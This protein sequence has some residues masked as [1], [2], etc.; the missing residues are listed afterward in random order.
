M[1]D[2]GNFNNAAENEEYRN[3]VLKTTFANQR[4]LYAAY[5]TLF[6]HGGIFIPTTR[7][8]KL[9]DAIYLLLIL[10]EDPQPYPLV[11]RVGWITPEGAGGQ[12]R[13]GIG[14]SFPSTAEAA[15]A[16]ARIEQQLASMLAS[17]SPTLTV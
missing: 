1:S 14:V 7:Q 5:I 13:A 11:C 4:D 6:S 15:Q 16:R 9:G 10:P 17:D 2:L 8:F 3:S 12:R